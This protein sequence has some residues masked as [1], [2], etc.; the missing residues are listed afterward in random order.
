MARPAFLFVMME[1]GEKVT[2]QEFH[3]WYEEE[4]IPLRVNKLSSFRTAARYRAI[5]GASPKWMAM[6]TV[7]DM[8]SFSDPEYTVLREQSSSREVDIIARLA[9]LDRRIYSLISDTN[10]MP[11][12]LRPSSIASNIVV[13][14][15]FTPVP[16]TEVKFHKWYEE[17]Y[18]PAL[19]EVPG[20]ARTRR[21]KL[22]DRGL[23]G[24]K[25]SDFTEELPQFLEIS[26]FD[27]L[28]A[29]GD[30]KFPSDTFGYDVI[31]DVAQTERRIFKL[32]TGYEPI[33]A[34][35]SIKTP[36]SFTPGWTPAGFRFPVTE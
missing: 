16:G 25:V 14:N 33:A 27:S 2:E 4:H 36:G 23:T 24:Q 18:V 10:P 13:A 21:Y 3:E 11:D 12:S 1:T 20:W 30:P 15:S 35:R 34:F 22:E 19:R 8:S 9:V 28:S 5:D 6:Y 26:E 32:L 29:L 31:G 17:D 7:E